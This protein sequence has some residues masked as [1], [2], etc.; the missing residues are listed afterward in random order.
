MPAVGHPVY[1]WPEDLLKPTVILFLTVSEDIRKQ[2]IEGRDEVKTFEEKR[3]DNDKLFRQRFEPLNM[4]L[5]YC[6]YIYAISL[7]ISQLL[8]IY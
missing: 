1:T 5:N 6:K 4:Y 8:R 3:L 7:T 2:R